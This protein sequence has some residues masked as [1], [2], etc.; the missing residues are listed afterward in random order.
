MDVDDLLPKDAIRIV[1]YVAIRSLRFFL[2]CA[3]IAGI[4]IGIIVT[5]ENI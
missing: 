3:L 5:I 2:W 4:L 1:T